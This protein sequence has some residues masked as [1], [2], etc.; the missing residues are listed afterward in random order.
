[1]KI[2]RFFA[3]LS[4]F[5]F[6]FTAFSQESGNLN[7]GGFALSVENSIYIS[8]NESLWRIEEGSAPEKIEEGSVS[9]LQAYDGRLYYLINEY[10]EDEF[11]FTSL[12]SQTPCTMLP[13]GTD[14]R[15]IGESLPVGSTFDFEGETMLL[16]AYIGYQGFTV[17]KGNIYYLANSGIGGKYVCTGDYGNGDGKLSVT[18]KYESGIALYRCGLNGE[19]TTRLTDVIGNSACAFAIEN[20]KIYLSSGYQDTIYAYNYVNYSILSLEGEVLSVFKNTFKEEDNPLKSDAGEFYHIPNALLPFEDQ[21][22]VSLSDSEGDF[23]ASQLFSLDSFGNM[24]KIAIEQQYVPSV[25]S[26]GSIY[27]VGSASLTNFYDDSINYADSFGIYRKGADEEGPG[28][29]LCP[30]RYDG[31]AFNL[32]ISVLL[33]YVYFKGETGEV[34]R[35]H[36]ESGETE[37]FTESGF[38]KASSFER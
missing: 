6:A 28:V 7:N 22:L 31:F 3:F 2:K 26:G 11:G 24:K 19:N 9:M 8:D 35:C 37:K 15:L 16:D 1:M 29:R 21:M 13:D 10:Q 30:I 5:L 18:G 27:Y 14:K 17:Y 4:L 12:K 20:D 32:K 38:V 33:D 36:T 25:L 34:Y 23:V